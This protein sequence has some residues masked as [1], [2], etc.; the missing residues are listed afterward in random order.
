MPG[1][2]DAAALQN[3]RTVPAMGMTEKLRHEKDLLGFYISGHPM[4]AYAGIDTAID[5]F[6]QAPTS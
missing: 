3:R 6:A 2:T 5:S 4:D 1:S